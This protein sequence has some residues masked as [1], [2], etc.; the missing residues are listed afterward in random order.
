[1]KKNKLKILFE[2]KCLLVVYKDYGIP[3]IKSEKYKNNLY[4]E[5][6]DYLHKKNQR[7]F[8][9]HRLDKDT[10]GL[11]LFA[12]DQKVKE[13]LQDNWDDVVR[14]YYAIVH[15]KTNQ[16]DEI[17][18]YIKETKSL[19]CYSTKDKSGELAKTLFKRVS[20]NKLYSLLEIE[21]KTGKKNQI[22]V[23]M[24]DN[25]T[26]ILGDK[27]YGKKDGFRHMALNAYYLKFK[28][29]ITKEKLEIDLGIPKEFQSIMNN[30]KN[31]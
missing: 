7:V 30:V 26:P 16:C 28:H 21:I 31:Q 15:G 3:T 1:M 4:S 18:S 10:G 20:F 9:V 6:Y 2:D 11:V 24:S 25:N 19:H 22:R 8:V 29:P 12:K 17:I 27:K 5:V 14:K 23:H 13:I